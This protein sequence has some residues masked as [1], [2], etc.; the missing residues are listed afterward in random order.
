MSEEQ[1]KIKVF[2]ARRFTKALN[3]LPKKQLRL[4]EDE[5]ENIITN[6]LLGDQKKGDLAYLRVHKFQ[7]N[8]QLVLLGYS[9]I[10]AQ[11]ELYLLQLGSHENFYKEI[12]VSSK[13]DKKL[14]Q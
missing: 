12:K 6:P 9:W 8:N 3:K 11:L 13:T 7:L 14:I 2:E 1:P 4:V 5:I 10:D